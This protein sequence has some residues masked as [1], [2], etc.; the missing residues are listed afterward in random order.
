M[1][2]DD[3]MKKLNTVGVPVA[4]RQFKKEEK[5]PYII[6]YSTGERPFP[7]D[8]EV[9]YRIPGMIVELY[10]KDKD[11]ELEDEVEKALSSFVFSKTET[12]LKDEKCN[13]II[14]EMEV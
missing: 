9:Y 4:Y 3:F 8:G 2:L 10:T 13:M 11:V 7:A 1:Y 14:Y 6:A 5:I 12:Y